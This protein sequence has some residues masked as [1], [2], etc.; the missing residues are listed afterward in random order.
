MPQKMEQ[1]LMLVW[2]VGGFFFFV[3]TVSPSVESCPGPG[4]A[5]GGVGY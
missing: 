2:W 1:S 3:F 5:R 4:W